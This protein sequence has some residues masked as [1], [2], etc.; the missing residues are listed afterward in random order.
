MREFER[1]ISS[2]K[3]IF[4]HLVDESLKLNAFAICIRTAKHMA[5]L[6]STVK[7]FDLDQPGNDFIVPSVKVFVIQRKFKEVSCSFS[8]KN[9]PTVAVARA[10]RWSAAT[11]VTLNSLDPLAVKGRPKR[12]KVH[13]EQFHDTWTWI[14][15]HNTS[16]FQELWIRGCHFS[17]VCPAVKI[18]SCLD[19]QAAQCISKLHLLDHFQ[20]D[21]V[22][23]KTSLL[24][25][26][27]VVSGSQ[28]ICEHTRMPTTSHAH[29]YWHHKWATLGMWGLHPRLFWKVVMSH[30]C[31]FINLQVLL[32]ILLDDKMNL[33]ESYVSQNQK[34][35]LKVVEF[36]DYLCS[37][38]VSIAQMTQ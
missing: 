17:F 30:A 10:S 33:V 24:L 19:L 9:E 26:A 4:Q 32:H 14:W 2:R 11:V 8:T 23:A 25:S 35:Q 15:G 3:Q 29:T 36:L 22:S 31:S 34:W 20:F 21:E 38:E 7:A 37:P 6:D 27:I 12:I 28:N 13:S 18:D 16:L 1:W 5:A